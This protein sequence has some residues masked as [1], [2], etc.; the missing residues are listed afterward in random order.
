M[1]DKPDYPKSKPWYFRPGND[2]NAKYN[3][4]S[5]IGMDQ[6]HYDNPDKRPTPEEEK[7]SYL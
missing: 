4:L 3:I 5:N 1:I 7:V 2:T 6:H